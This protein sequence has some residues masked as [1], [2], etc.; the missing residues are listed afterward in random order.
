VEGR[1]AIVGAKFSHNGG[2][3]IIPRRILLN[4][5]RRFMHISAIVKVTVKINKKNVG[6]IVTLEWQ[7]GLQ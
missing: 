7:L 2:K 3:A 5:N 4:V 1:E 6:M